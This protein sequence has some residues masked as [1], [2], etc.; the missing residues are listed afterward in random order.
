L[1]LAWSIGRQLD[2]FRHDFVFYIT[3]R[4]ALRRNT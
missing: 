2:D 4:P 1:T 3:A